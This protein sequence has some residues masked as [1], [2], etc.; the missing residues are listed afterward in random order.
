MPQLS[1]TWD[2]A[3]GAVVTLRVGVGASERRRLRQ[4]NRPIPQPGTISALIDTG[5]EVTCVDPAAVQTLGLASI[6]PTLANLPAGGGLVGARRYLAAIRLPHPSGDPKDDFVV[7]DHPL[8]ELPIG[9][10]GFEMLIGRDLL[11]L[12][13]LRFD[14]PGRAFTLDY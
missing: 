2:P 6:G 14:G 9:A 1:D 12:C 11:A 3:D 5:A 13:V 7:T 10:L 8:T 4:A